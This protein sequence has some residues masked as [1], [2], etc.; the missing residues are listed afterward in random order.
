MHCV[1]LFMHICVLCMHI[2]INIDIAIWG[3]MYISKEKEAMNLRSREDMGKDGERGHRKDWNEKRKGG[4][5]V[6]P[7]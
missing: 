1:H 6:I 2:D 5:D 3:Y 7:L 4:N